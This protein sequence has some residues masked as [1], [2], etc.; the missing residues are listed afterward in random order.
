MATDQGR[1][2]STHPDLDGLVGYPPDAL[3]TDPARLVADLK[4][5]LV[6]DFQSFNVPLKIAD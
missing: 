4:L 3:G 6:P 1:C 2:N 5:N